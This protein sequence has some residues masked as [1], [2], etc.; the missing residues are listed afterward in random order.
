MLPHRWPSSRGSRNLT[1]FCLTAKAR[2]CQVKPDPQEGSHSSARFYRRPW[3][4]PAIGRL[5]FA[6]SV[7][8]GDN[9]RM[10]HPDILVIGAGIIGCGLAPRWPVPT[11]E[12]AKIGTW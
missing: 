1:M 8:P 12:A 7:Y 2:P 5:R 9:A 3:H 11:E 4:V 6:K 10:E